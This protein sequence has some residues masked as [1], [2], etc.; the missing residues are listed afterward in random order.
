MRIKA[1][2]GELRTQS[3][4]LTWSG[5][6]AALS[7]GGSSWVFSGSVQNT[8]DPDLYREVRYGTSSFSYLLPATPGA[9]VL[10]LYFFEG[11]GSK[12]GHSPFSVAANGIMIL[13]H[14]DIG[15]EAGGAGI[16]LVKTFPT[17]LGDNG[18]NL[19]FRN[20]SSRAMVSAIELLPAPSAAVSSSLPSV[21]FYAGSTAYADPIT[22]SSW[23]PD[24]A[25]SRGGGLY[26]F[27]DLGLPGNPGDLGL[28]LG[29]R[30]SGASFQVVSTLP[31]GQY[32]VTLYFYEGD[33]SQVGQSPFDVTA[34]GS[35]LLSGFDIGTAAGGAGKALKKTFTVQVGA[36]GLTLS[37]QNR[38]AGHRA[39]VSAIEITP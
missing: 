24:S 38:I 16:A 26:T 39:M 27:S 35:T 18:L 12:V 21:R 4:G 29:V 1:G 34:N 17:V 2:G 20:E 10:K 9:Y 32:Q 13:D 15:S 31:A 33:S 25:V 37:F 36:S 23:S 11:D 7:S 6:G 30:Y 5:D 19:T 8:P 22:G 3:N 14:F 28:Y